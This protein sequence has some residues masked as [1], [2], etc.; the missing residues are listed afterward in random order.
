MLFGYLLMRDSVEFSKKIIADGA[1][2]GH[3]EHPL[4]R[5]RKK[6][7]IFSCRTP[8]VPAETIWVLPDP[9]G[10][11]TGQV[12]TEPTSITLI[13]TES[14]RGYNGPGQVL[15]PNSRGRWMVFEWE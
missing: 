10:E 3:E 2:A 15:G 1:V 14:A 4:R 8:M 11:R 12:R 7:S 13:D 9:R 5:A 6:R